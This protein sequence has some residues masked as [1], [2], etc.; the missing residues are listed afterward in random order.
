MKRIP[1]EEE[2]AGYEKDLDA[3]YAY[4]TFYGKTN[5]EM[6]P[7]FRKNVIER[8]DEI[9]FMPR[10]AFQYYIFGLRDYVIR[11]DFELYE[12]SD[13]ASCFIGLVLEKLRKEPESVQPII[14]EL[15][16]DLQFVAGNQNLYEADKDIYGD[17]TAMYQDIVRLSRTNA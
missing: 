8:T 7:A 15:L 5:E 1:T 13:A 2:W 6:Q 12:S 17:F 14:S 9:R 3:K 10:G 4:K 11:Q 16:P